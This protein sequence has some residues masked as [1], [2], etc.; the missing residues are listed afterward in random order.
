MATATADLRNFYKTASSKTTNPETER[1]V[2]SASIGIKNYY[3]HQGIEIS[4]SNPKATAFVIQP[5]V[6]EI[7]PSEEEYLATSRISNVY[8]LEA[9]PGQAVR[10]Y[11]RSLV[12]ELAWLNEHEENLSVS[13]HE[14]LGLL[15][16]YLQIV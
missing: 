16:S 9:T 6:I 15:Q 1:V 14:E 13:I 4:I 11:L 12:N 10:S 3:I 2:A 7:T 5:F 8:E